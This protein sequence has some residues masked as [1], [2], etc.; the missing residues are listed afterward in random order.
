M[1]ALPVFNI[2][3]VNKPLADIGVFLTNAD[4]C[5]TGNQRPG[6]DVGSMFPPT[7]DIERLTVC[8]TAGTGFHFFG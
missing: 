3:N 6:Y 5:K 8:V 2:V 4:A 7:F 1:E